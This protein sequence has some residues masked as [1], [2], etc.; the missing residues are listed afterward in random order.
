MKN[1]RNVQDV[2]DDCN[3]SNDLYSKLTNWSVG[4]PVYD[5]FKDTVSFSEKS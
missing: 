3:Q 4:V 5:S 1:E 2:P